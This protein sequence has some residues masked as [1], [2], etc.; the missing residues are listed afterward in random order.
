MQYHEGVRAM[1]LAEKVGNIYQHP[2]DLG[3][4]ENLVSVGLSPMLGSSWQ[5]LWCLLIASSPFWCY[6][7]WVRESFAG[8]VQHRNTLVPA[9]GFVHFMTAHDLQFW[10]DSLYARVTVKPICLMIEWK[11]K[12]LRTHITV[13]SSAAIIVLFVSNPAFKLCLWI[14]NVYSFTALKA[15]DVVDDD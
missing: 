5:L 2:Y 14:L 7:C 4:Y 12:T 6:R 13:S 9:L 11:G 3:V 1:W 8:C 10:D 15:D